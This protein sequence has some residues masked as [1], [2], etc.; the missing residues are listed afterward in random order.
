M[1]YNAARQDNEIVEKIAL[2]LYSPQ[3][4][5]TDTYEKYDLFNTMKDVR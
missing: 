1:Q 5:D 3:E 4:V 2:L